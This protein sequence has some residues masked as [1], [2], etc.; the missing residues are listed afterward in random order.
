V[1]PSS[2]FCNDHVILFQIN[3]TYLAMRV[4][5]HFVINVLYGQ[6][7]ENGNLI[8][9]KGTILKINFKFVIFC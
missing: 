9:E 4:L 6:D 1:T 8:V 5:N 3:L 2:Y 7:S